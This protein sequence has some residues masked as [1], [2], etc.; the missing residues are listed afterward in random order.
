[1]VEVGYKVKVFGVWI[2]CPKWVFEIVERL[3]ERTEE[4]EH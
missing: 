1:M 2:R 3:T 4:N